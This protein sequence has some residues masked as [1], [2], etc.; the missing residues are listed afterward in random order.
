MSKDPPKKRGAGRGD[1][2][3][4]TRRGGRKGK[5]LGRR[6]P[7]GGRLRGKQEAMWLPG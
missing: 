5:A 6:N 3:T 2:W 1:L 7:V 4:K